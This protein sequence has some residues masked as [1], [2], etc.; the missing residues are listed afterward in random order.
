M[1]IAIA[2][3]KGGTGKTT[4]S[5]NLA[6]LLKEN[7]Y[8]VLLADCDVEEPNDDIFFNIEWKE[9]IEP[10]ILIPEVDPNKCTGCGECTKACQYHAIVNI[11]KK[12]IVF[13]EL[14]HGCGLCTYACPED[15]IREVKRPIGKISNG[16]TAENIRFFKGLLNIGE[17]VTTSLI[18]NLLK[19]ND[20]NEKNYDFY[21]YDS[22]PGTSCPVI[23]TTKNADYILLV[24]EP[25]P[26]GLNDLKMA[27]E[28]IRKL[29][30]DFG[31]FV[32]KSTIGNDDLWN[33]CKAEN[34]EIL[35]QL[36]NSREIATSYS[37]GGL[38]LKDFPA[39]RKEF[40]KIY[41]KIKV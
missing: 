26:F 2:S 16:Y 27:V 9:N 35:G 33:Y 23:E 37:S 4:I 12:T 13:P 39:Y 21:L 38:I 19:Y 29:G 8:R 1:K 32:N 40:L 11:G 20:E 17:T 14:C 22:P 6:Y 15:A 3:G 34:I 25:T 36:P 24:T 30:K 18:T 31:V 10:F 28:M 41:S 5:T 7:N